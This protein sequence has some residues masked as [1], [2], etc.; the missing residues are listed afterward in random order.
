LAA[1]RAAEI[2][3]ASK[4]AELESEVSTQ[5]KRIADLEEAYASLELE[6]ENVTAGYRRL[7]GKYKK[8]CRKT[9]CE[10]PDAAK[11]HMAQ[12]AEVDKK[13]AKETKTTRTMVGM[14]DTAFAIF[15]RH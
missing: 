8:T 3:Q 15:M 14:S 1:R 2:A 10:K 6:K 11:A 9:E 5:T 13:L 4:I 12:L 7:A